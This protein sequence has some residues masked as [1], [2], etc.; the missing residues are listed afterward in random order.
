MLEC[1]QVGYPAGTCLLKGGLAKL[2][3]AVSK[4]TALNFGDL[5]MKNLSPRTRLAALMLAGALAPGA[6][7]AQVFL[8][9]WYLN[10]DGTGFGGAG[11]IQVSQYL[12]FVGNSYIQNYTDNTYTTPLPANSALNTPF[13]FKDNGVFR[14]TSADNGPAF[15]PSTA[16]NAE[17][18]ALYAGGTGTGTLGGPITFNPGAALDLY[19]GSTANYATATGSGVYYGAN[20]GTDIGSFVQTSGS[21]LVDVTGVP[22]GQLTLVFQATNLAPGYWF[23][24]SGT[25]LSTLVGSGLLFG[26]VTTNAS[27]VDTP[28]TVLV[29][30]LVDGLANASTTYTNTP[31]TDFIVSN[32]GQFRIETRTVPEPA[33]IALLGIGLLGAS[34]TRKR[35]VS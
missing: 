35:K 27:Y 12:D 16:T 26:F 1:G 34:L 24:S 11:Q 28:T 15:P 13:A 14:I 31:A 30:Q 21:G 7:S 2:R 4:A 29:D 19:A 5:G 25:D 32:N 3:P 18:T 23:D 20:D 6:A 33:S 17:M 10:I 9:D 22:N 8:T